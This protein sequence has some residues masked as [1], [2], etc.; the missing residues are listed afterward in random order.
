M[1][2]LGL[3]RRRQRIPARADSNAIVEKE[4]TDV[5]RENPPP[6]LGRER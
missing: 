4:Q 6:S 5:D 1:R 2:E 3:I